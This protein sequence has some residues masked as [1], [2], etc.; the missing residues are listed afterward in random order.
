MTTEVL[1]YVTSFI[2]GFIAG[3]IPFSTERVS[4]VEK[5]KL[6]SQE[7]LSSQSKKESLSP[8]RA[9]KIDDSKFVTEVK[10]NSLSE[11]SGELGVQTTVE[12]DV[13][14]SVSRLAH[15]KKNR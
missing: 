6:L 13:G 11:K 2:L 1:L 15:L 9:V 14:K 10:T 5:E 7:S 4:Y 12:D 8:R 3:K